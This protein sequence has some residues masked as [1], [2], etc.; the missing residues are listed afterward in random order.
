MRSEKEKRGRTEDTEGTED[1]AVTGVGAGTRNGCWLRAKRQG[2]KIERI[3]KSTLRNL[4]ALRVLRAI[5]SFSRTLTGTPRIT[6]R[7]LE[8]Y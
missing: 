8:Y 2:V 5:S 7:S 4:R 3:F 1:L 6:F